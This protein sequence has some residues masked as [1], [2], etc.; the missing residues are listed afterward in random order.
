MV[1]GRLK[2]YV[3]ILPPY[4]FVYLKNCDGSELCLKLYRSYPTCKMYLSD[5]SMLK[6]TIPE[7][8]PDEQSYLKIVV[9]NLSL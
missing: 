4:K 7:S 2:T 8:E 1:R 6:S 9:L 3:L 5:R